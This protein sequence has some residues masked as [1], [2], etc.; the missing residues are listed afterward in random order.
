MTLFKFGFLTLTLIDLIDIILLIP[1]GNPA[2]AHLCG[3]NSIFPT[4]FHDGDLP[5]IGSGG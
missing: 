2:I 3:T 5:I 4:H 1:T